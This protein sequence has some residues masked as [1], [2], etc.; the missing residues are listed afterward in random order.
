MDVITLLL[1]TVALLAVRIVFGLL[2]NNLCRSR[3]AKVR[4]MIVLGSGGHTAEMMSLLAGFSV[5]AYCPRCYVVAD[6]DKMSG[7]KAEAFEQLLSLS[8]QRHNTDQ[9]PQNQTS[10]AGE[11]APKQLRPRRRAHGDDTAEGQPLELRQRHKGDA[12]SGIRNGCWNSRGTTSSGIA[13]E[14]ECDS[15][16]SSL[17][18][19]VRSS[20]RVVRIPRSRE[21]GQSF[22]T[23]V[24]ST[25]YASG[26]ALKC[27]LTFRPD[28]VLANGPGT[29]IPICAAAA[30]ARLLGVARGRV[31][32]VESIARVYRLSLSGRILYHTRLADRFFVQWPDLQR[33][34]PRCAYAGRVM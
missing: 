14:A 11:E 28:L 21:V 25:I 17:R 20:Y 34:Y 7:Q 19:G 18:G 13:M 24:G 6:T 2:C 4:T 32:Y 23:S 22:L 26:A 5:E 16:S 31:V 30:I 29:C 15:H 10:A 9:A 8:T 33:R 12:A 1:C 3:Y 27:V